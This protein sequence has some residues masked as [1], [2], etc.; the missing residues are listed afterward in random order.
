[1]LKARNDNFML[2]A[3]SV[4]ESIDLKGAQEALKRY[5][6]LNRDH[7]V[8]IQ[9]LDHQ[10]V[11]LTKFGVVV[12]WNVS[13][14]DRKNIISDIAP[15]VRAKNPIEAY[16]EEMSAVQQDGTDRVTSEGVYLAKID[17]SRV[18]IVSYA[19]AQSVALERY[20]FDV[21][22]QLSE[23]ETVITNLKN[24]GKS[25]LREKDLLKQVGRTLAVKQTAISH[26]ALFDKP[27]EV[28]ESPELERLYLYLSSEFD[29]KDRFSVLD[30][31]IYFLSENSRMLMEF[32]AEKKNAFLET[33][34]I[35]L[36][37]IEMIPLAID[38]T[39][40]LIQ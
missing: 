25:L 31:K 28:W 23:L 19:I 37:L 26:L 34:I 21:E 17:V 9:Y 36:I 27:D 20:E 38:L 11:V 33:V 10:Y 16:K 24:T 13:D 18:K 29:I 1:M 15:H 40:Y 30:Q 39:R 22:K 7:P 32:M 12:F 5:T 35:V 8:V 4:G 2:V 3:R 6:F 14:N